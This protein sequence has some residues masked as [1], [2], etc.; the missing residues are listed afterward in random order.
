MSVASQIVGLPFSMAYYFF[1]FLV[2]IQGEKSL[3][4]LEIFRYAKKI[5]ACYYSKILII[6]CLG[7]V[8]RSLYLSFISYML[9]I[10]PNYLSLGVFYFPLRFF[11]LN[12]PSVFMFCFSYTMFAVVCIDLE[13]SYLTRKHISQEA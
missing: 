10:L 3:E 13:K 5:V 4:G 8:M 2:V 12:I 6:I 9:D 11:V 1:A 7:I